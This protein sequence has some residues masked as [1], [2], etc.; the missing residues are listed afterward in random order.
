MGHEQAEKESRNCGPGQGHKTIS[1]PNPKNRGATASLSHLKDGKGQ[2][3]L[4]EPP[5]ES[6][7]NCIVGDE[8]LRRGAD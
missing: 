1:F 5:E 7:C 4:F 6:S 8:Q 3:G 2:L